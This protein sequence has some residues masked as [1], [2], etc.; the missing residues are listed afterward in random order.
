MQIS[1]RNL[2]SCLDPQALHMRFC[3]P[4]YDFSR[5]YPFNCPRSLHCQ[6]FQRFSQENYEETGRRTCLCAAI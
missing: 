2:D 5:G 6:I 4:K 3:P 1:L